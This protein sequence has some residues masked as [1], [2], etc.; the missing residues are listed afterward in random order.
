M[1]LTNEELRSLN[2]LSDAELERRLR[3]EAYRSQL[4]E[5]FGKEEYESLRELLAAPPHFAGPG[6]EII[7]LPGI[8]GSELA[9]VQGEFGKVWVDLVGLSLGNDFAALRLD[10]AGQNDATPG[11]R[12]E[13][14]G[15]FKRAYFKTQT[16]L[17]MR[18][19][20]IHTFAY[21][22]RKALDTSALRLR[23]FVEAKTAGDA[24]KQFVFIAHSMGGLVVRRYLDLCGAQAED[25][26][27]KLIMLGTPN[28]GSYVP[29]MAMKGDDFYVQIVGF[30]YGGAQARSIIQTFLGLYQMF[31]NPDIFGQ[32]DIYQA[33]YWDE[34]AVSPQHLDAAQKF[35]QQLKARLPEK[36]FLIANRSL[37]TV[38][39]VQREQ[40]GKG[41]R[42]KFLGAKVGD[43]TVPFTSA[44]LRDVPTYETSEKHS[45]MQKDETVLR[46]I[47]DLI[48]EGQTDRLD[49]YVPTFAAP[50]EPE[51]LEEIALGEVS[52][53]L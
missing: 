23:D 40:D 44:Y 36:M 12:I 42:Y 19:H 26:L 18:G 11:S 35:H 24:N 33:G 15:L 34:A 2:A 22:W 25:R 31:P 4:Q 8:M 29:P 5:Y 51:S 52:L 47:H 37:K 17:W 16:W 30:L 43:G 46:A 3:D 20:A 50:L 38:T 48:N 39:H 6:A 45:E 41:W 13:P 1:A 28:H 53:E 14:A 21:D 10:P 9:D 32:P 27:D 49:R 7:L